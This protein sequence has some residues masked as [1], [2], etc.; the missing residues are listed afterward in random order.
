MLEICGYGGFYLTPPVATSNSERSVRLC[1]AVAHTVFSS[2][3]VLTADDCLEHTTAMRLEKV[4]SV[5]R[6]V[7]M[8]IAHRTRLWISFTRDDRIETLNAL[9]HWLACC[10]HFAAFTYTSHNSIVLCAKSSLISRHITN[11]VFPLL[12]CW[13]SR[14]LIWLKVRFV[15]WVWTVACWFWC[16]CLGLGKR[17]LV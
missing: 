4:T 2:C 3:F 8:V 11:W 15:Y 6:I 12:A 7:L 9:Q 14:C 1:I 5:R 17:L 13:L 10:G 16:W